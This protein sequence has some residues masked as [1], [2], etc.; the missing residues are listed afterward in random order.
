MDWKCK[1]TWGN[2]K[3]NTLRKIKNNNR[4]LTEK[5]NSAKSYYYK[6]KNELLI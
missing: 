5:N 4:Y 6:P 2:P 3:I 1:T